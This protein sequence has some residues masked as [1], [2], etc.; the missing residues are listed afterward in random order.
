MPYTYFKEIIDR[1]NLRWITFR[2]MSDI[3]KN[4]TWLLCLKRK[5]LYP[6]VLPAIIYGLETRTVNIRNYTETA[7]YTQK[8]RKHY[9][10][11]G[12]E[13]Q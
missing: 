13:R 10:A 4:K 2:K 3:L 5:I 7:D 11:N 8:H 1:I 6:C 12:K 9:A